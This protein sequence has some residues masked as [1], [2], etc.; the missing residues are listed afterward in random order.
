MLRTVIATAIIAFGFVFGAG[1]QA[2]AQEL[3]PCAREG[4][5]CRV[6]YPTRVIYGV[7]GRSVERFVRQGGVACSN[8]VFGDP[9][10][11][12]PKRCAF[13]ARRLDPRPGRGHDHRRDRWDPRHGYIPPHAHPHRVYYRTY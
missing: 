5:F 8:R 2:Q 12:R 4:G 10:Y 7:P 3:V 13:V 9:A 11:G 1:L 6:P